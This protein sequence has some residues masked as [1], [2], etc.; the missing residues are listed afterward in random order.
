M[1]PTVLPLLSNY[2]PES[3]FLRYLGQA[4]PCPSRLLQ[5]LACLLS[6][7]SLPYYLILAKYLNTCILSQVLSGL[8][9][10][11]QLF[12]TSFKTLYHGLQG[13]HGLA[14]AT[15]LLQAVPPHWLI[16]FVLNIPSTFLHTLRL[17]VPWLTSL[18]CHMLTWLSPP[19]PA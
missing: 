16:R 19:R 2:G 1:I 8:Y 10:F 12:I 11:Q 3:V 17:F 6:H 5:I 7:P 14:P 15:S 18:P 13:P 4:I 9:S